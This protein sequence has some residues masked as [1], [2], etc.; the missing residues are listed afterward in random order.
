MIRNRNKPSLKT[1]RSRSSKLVG[2]SV[3]LTWLGVICGV[4]LLTFAIRNANALAEHEQ[5]E[6]IHNGLELSKQDMATKL[7]SITIWDEAVEKINNNPDPAF[8]NDNVGTWFSNY[9]GFPTSLVLDGNDR[10]S[11]FYEDGA[12]QDVAKASSVAAA[13]AP[14]VSE[15]REQ[16]KKD[17]YKPV[18]DGDTY[19]P[20]MAVDFVTID[21]KAALVGLSTIVPD[22]AKVLPKPGP[23]A[24]IV[25][26][27]PVTGGLIEHIA[28]NTLVKH[29]RFTTTVPRKGDGFVVIKANN[30]ADVGAFEW[31]P[32]SPGRTILNMVLQPSLAIITVILA[33]SLIVYRESRKTSDALVAS[34]ARALHIAQHDELTGLNNRH[35][36]TERLKVE[37]KR[38]G[39]PE[40]SALLFIDIDRFKEIND[41][42]GLAA[43]DELLIQIGGRFKRLVGEQGF[44]ARL[45]G[46]EFAMFLTDAGDQRIYAF[47]RSIKETLKKPIELVGASTP[48]SATVGVA[49]IDRTM[50]DDSEIT[51]WAELALN[52]A[53]TNGRGSVVQYTDELDKSI[54]MRRQLGNDIRTSLDGHEF[55]L[56]YQPLVD[57][58][59][60]QIRGVEAL[61]RWNHRTRGP[62]SPGIFIPIAESAGLIRD[63][64][65]WVMRRAF[66]DSL[67]W[68]NLTVAI[69]VSPI[70]MKHPEFVNDVKAAL[71]AT[72]AN[73]RQICL[74][75]TEG[76]LLDHSDTLKS[77]LAELR[78][79]GFKI[80]LDDFGTGYSSLDYLH[81]Y[82]F[83]RIKIDK[84]F[85]QGL[86]TVM[87]AAGDRAVGH[88]AVAHVRRGRGGGRRGDRRAIRL[89]QIRRRRP[90][91][92]LLLL[93]G[94]AAGRDH[95]AR[96]RQGARPPAAGRLT[97]RKRH[98]RAAAAE[99][100][101]GARFPEPDRCSHRKSPPPRRSG[102]S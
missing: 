100:M 16:A 25:T 95:R 63:V 50:T 37:L 97:P 65:N 88:R 30:G 43:G 62:I 87:Q 54:Q 102:C 68:P 59:T 24:I 83:D 22:F 8:I 13:I 98:W 9:V 94:A 36:F 85:V 81:R 14:L 93:R 46:D 69:N 42:M 12:E 35:W 80:V 73:A 34:E 79:L 56:L 75:I 82:D 53:R 52:K 17:G 49:L 10:V 60:M 38:E 66:R 21:G 55:H 70:H 61:I 23:S 99:A 72:R 101:V 1:K 6:L 15:I 31:D 41:S 71:V 58:R 19:A 48:S 84:S 64:S 20:R 7:K 78:R 76:V 91:P 47:T 51:R 33:G 67:R 44:L 40:T 90:D 74:E 27:L 92:G 2:A 18:K 26:I 4:V 3:V 57:A 39:R 89:H 96:P 29:A 45:S 28:S 86:D 11:Y 32:Y 77:C 5:A